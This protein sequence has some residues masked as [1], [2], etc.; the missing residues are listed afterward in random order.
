MTTPTPE[1]AAASVRGR[2]AATSHAEIERAAFALFAER[3]F[4][5]T[6][7]DAIAEA[8]GVGR[9]TLLRYF[10][11]K[12]DICWGQFDLT[13]AAFHTLL[14]DTPAH[15]PLWER[16]HRGV[17][18]F[19]G[20]PDQ[21]MAAHRERMRLILHTPALTA[22]S[23]LRYAQWRDV[24]A[25]FVADQTGATP[26]DLLPHLVGQVSLA[27]TLSAYEQWLADEDSDLAG[28]IDRAMTALRNYLS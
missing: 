23:V 5:A 11:S 27:L 1:P 2:P 15:L 20:F 28:V 22:H 13:L 26:T 7:L 18:A 17:V 16:V 19:N 12:N 25:Q 14:A 4:E 3:G 9:R 21:A 6:T 10:P 8:V 24:V